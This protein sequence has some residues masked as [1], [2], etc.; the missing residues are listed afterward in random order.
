MRGAGH[1]AG[2]GRLLAYPIEMMPAFF[3]AIYPLLPFTYL[4]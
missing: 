2:A 1:S 4:D 3:R